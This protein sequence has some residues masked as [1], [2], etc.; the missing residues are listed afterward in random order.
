MEYE[1]TIDDEDCKIYSAKTGKT[2]RSKGS[3]RGHHIEGTGRT[4]SEAKRNWIDKANYL[5]NE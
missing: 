5:A 4:E 2:W 1:I 3:F